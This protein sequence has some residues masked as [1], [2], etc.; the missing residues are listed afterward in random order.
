LSASSSSSSRYI[1]SSQRKS[2]PFDSFI[3]IQQMK[4]LFCSHRD[5]L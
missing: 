1:C 5:L 3:Y 2:L 4:D